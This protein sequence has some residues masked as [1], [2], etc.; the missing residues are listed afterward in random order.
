MKNTDQNYGQFVFVLGIIFMVFTSNDTLGFIIMCAGVIVLNQS[1]SDSKKKTKDFIEEANN[2]QAND[3]LEGSEPTVDVDLNELMGH[4][5]FNSEINHQNRKKAVKLCQK[6]TG[7][8]LRQAE[9]AVDK[10]LKKYQ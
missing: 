4:P 3:L 10:I 2:T 5:E 1:N 7:C 6:I 9:E 8:S